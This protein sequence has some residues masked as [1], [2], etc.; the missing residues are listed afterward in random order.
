MKI[1]FGLALDGCEAV[2]PAHLLNGTC[3]GPLGLIQIL[4]TR[5]GLKSESASA[6]LRVTQYRTLLKTLAEEQEVFYRAS[7]EKDSYA[8]AETLLRWR[9]DLVE[10]GWD[11]Q[12]APDDSKRLQNLAAL[13]IRAGT[14][15]SLGLADRLKSIVRELACRS[16]QIESL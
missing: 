7:F 12:V 6:A 5:L 4:E 10:A 9:D 15:L 3:C 14:L 1:T 2:G 8:V 16:P 11:G 13:E